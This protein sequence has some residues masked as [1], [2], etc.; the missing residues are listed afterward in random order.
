M[1]LLHQVNSSNLSSEQEHTCPPSS[2]GEIANIRYPFR[3]KND[4][5]HCGDSRYELSWENNLTVLYLYSEK[6][7]V[8]SINYNNFTVRLVDPGVQESNCSSI[9]LNYLSQ[10]NFCDT[11][12]SVENKTCTDPY[13]AQR[14]V[15]D[16]QLLFKHIIY[17]NCSHQVT[18]NTRFVNAS[19]CLNSNSKGYYIYAI[20]G[21][22]MAEDILVGCHVKLV[23]PTSWSGLQRKYQLH[24]YDAIHKAL[25][26]G[27]DIS[28]L[29]LT[30]HNRCGD[31]LSQCS[32][33]ISSEII[34][35]FPFRRLCYSIFGYGW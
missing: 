29:R 4:P 32:F 34:E 17:V 6:Y 5:K 20:A 16:Y 19:S 24:S 12:E 23:V 21:D 9:P 10:S 30:C 15:D 2:C 28:W 18:K 35:C 7:H 13:Q 3:L 8:K 25:V 22:L 26:Y 1:L 11:Y 33:N 14:E 31:D 27:F